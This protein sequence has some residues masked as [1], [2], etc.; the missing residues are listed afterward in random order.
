MTNS[1]EGFVLSQSSSVPK[2]G[3]PS[4]S[5]LSKLNAPGFES[6]TPTNLLLEDLIIDE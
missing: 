3:T 6:T 1:A 5:S 2:Y 4:D